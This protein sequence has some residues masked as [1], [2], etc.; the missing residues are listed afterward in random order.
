[1]RSTKLSVTTNVSAE[2]ETPPI[3]NV[4]LCGRFSFMLHVKVEIVSLLF[5]LVIPKVFKILMGRLASYT[6]PISQFFS[7]PTS[8]SRVEVQTHSQSF[9]CQV[10]AGVFQLF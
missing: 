1:M 2:H 5:R 4:L 7:C 6:S 10:L 9:L 8:Q 3:A